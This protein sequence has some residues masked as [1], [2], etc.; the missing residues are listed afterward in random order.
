MTKTKRAGGVAQMGEYLSRKLKAMSQTPVLL[1]LKQGSLLLVF[2][3]QL[4]L[5]L[6]IL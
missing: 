6:D 3:H 4:K 2:N 1:P 5:I